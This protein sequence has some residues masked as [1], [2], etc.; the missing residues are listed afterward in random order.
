MREDSLPQV[1]AFKPGRSTWLSFAWEESEV[2]PSEDLM[3]HIDAEKL[4][5]IGQA[6]TRML[7]QIVRQTRF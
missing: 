2:L 6:F 4:Q 5:V 3:E 1:E 7:T